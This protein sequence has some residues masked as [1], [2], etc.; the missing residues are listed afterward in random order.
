MK[1]YTVYGRPLVLSSIRTIW[2]DARIRREHF[3]PLVVV[4]LFLVLVVAFT[5]FPN[6][7]VEQTRRH[8]AKLD[9]EIC[10]CV[11]IGDSGVLRTIRRFGTSSGRYND[12]DTPAIRSVVI[13]LSDQLL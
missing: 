8:V 2:T 9:H 3:Q 10:S 11:N 5:R 6:T 13:S 1:R 4:L 7:T 12:N